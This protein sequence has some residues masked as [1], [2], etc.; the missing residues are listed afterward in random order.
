MLTKKDYLAYKPYDYCE[1]ITVYLFSVVLLIVAQFFVGV[2]AV[3]FGSIAPELSQSGDFNGAC[4]I[5][6]Q[7]VEAGFLFLYGVKKKRRFDFSYFNNYETGSG[8]SV[9]HVLLPVCIAPLV[10]IGMYLPTVWYGYLTEAIGIPPEAGALSLD[11]VSAV[12]LVVIAS[13][14]LAPIVEETIYR[15]V[16]LS[17]LKSERTI[18]TAAL[19]SSLSFMLMHLSPLQ[20]VFQFA[21][22]ITSA[23]IAIRAKRLLPCVVLHATSNALA[24]TLEMT[25]LAE[26]VG[27][28]VEWLTARPLAAFFITLG[29]FI[30][31]GAAV[32][33]IVRFGFFD[34]RKNGGAAKNTA[35]RNPVVGSPFE[36]LDGDVPPQ[37]ETTEVVREKAIGETKRRDGNFRYWIAVGICAL[38]FIINLVT[39]IIS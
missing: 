13:V 31:A 38:V 18:L 29:L 6:F 21:L 23:F 35:Q 27:A 19:L 30:A 17:A 5:F 15:G 33:F 11:T 14:F 3:S 12:V 2:V 22:G 20:V 7:V 26:K 37:A 28:S 4:M 1:G 10:L 36:E 16:L 39:L 8:L 34:K 9:R 24:L 25:P 32:F